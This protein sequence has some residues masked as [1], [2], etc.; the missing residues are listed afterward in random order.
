MTPVLFAYLELAGNIDAVINVAATVGQVGEEP[1][2]PIVVRVGVRSL[3]A[4][5]FAETG[6]VVSPAVC[7]CSEA[8]AQIVSCLWTTE[9]S[10]LINQSAHLS[11]YNTVFLKV[12]SLIVVSFISR[13]G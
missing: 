3:D 12:T 6:E 13:C 8:G 11:T 2:S 9:K 1:V 4:D 7:Y 5:A 10:I